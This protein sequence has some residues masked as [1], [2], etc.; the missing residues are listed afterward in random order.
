[1]PRYKLRIANY[2]LRIPLRR[3][4]PLASALGIGIAL[5]WLLTG[6]TRPAQASPAE[7]LPQ[8]PEAVIRYVDA[9]VGSDGSDC[10]QPFVLDSRKPCATIQWA[11]DVAA[12]GDVVKV[13]LG[14]YNT[15]NGKGGLSQVVYIDKQVTVEGGY[16]SGFFG[17]PN[18]AIPAVID[19]GNGGR[20][21]V[22]TGSAPATLRGFRVTH[23][24]ASALNGNGGG[25]LVTGST[26]ATLEFV[27]VEDSQA[28]RGGGLAVESGSLTGS[29]VVLQRN[30]A[31]QNG[32][33]AF[34]A[35]G[36]ANITNGAIDANTAV[37][38]GGVYAEGGLFSFTGAAMRTNIA[39]DRGGAVFVAGG[40]AVVGGGEVTAN[41]APNGGGAGYATGGSLHFATGTIMHENLIVTGEGQALY[42]TNARGILTGTIIQN[43]TGAAHA[44]YAQESFLRIT[45]GSSLLNNSLATGDGGALAAHGGW[46]E[47]ETSSALGNSAPAGNGGAFS[48]ITSTLVITGGTLNSNTSFGHG[49]AIYALTTTITATGST[50]NENSAQLNGGA[51]YILTGTVASTSNSLGRNSA[52]QN[53]GAIFGNDSGLVIDGGNLTDNRVTIGSGGGIFWN[54]QYLTGTNGLVLRGNLAGSDAFA[55]QVANPRAIDITAPLTQ[56]DVLTSSGGGI[57]AR[58]VSMHLDEVSFD[59]NRAGYLG[60]ALYVT[61]TIDLITITNGL[62]TSNQAAFGQG[63]GFYFANITSTVTNTLFS[64]NLAAWGGGLYMLGGHNAITGSSFTSNTA[65]FDGGGIYARGG[66]VSFSQITAQQ[67]VA[68]KGGGLFALG[69]TGLITSSTIIANDAFHDGGGLYLSGGTFS[70]INNVLARNRIGL[71]TAKGSALYILGARVTIAH[72]TISNNEHRHLDGFGV[73]SAIYAAQSST[74]LALMNSIIANHEEGLAG[75]RRVKVEGGGNVW[76]NNSKRNWSPNLIGVDA[77]NYFG[78]PLFL[79]PASLDYN[80]QRKSAAWGVGLPVTP[81]LASDVSTD[82][83][84]GRRIAV[85]DAGAYEHRYNRGLNLEQSASPRVLTPTVSLRY[86]ITVSNYSRS[87][88]PPVRFSNVL[89][90]QQTAL[91]ITTDRGVCDPVALTCEL[92]AFNIGDVALISL[93][94]QVTG[95][96]LTGGIVTMTNQANVTFTPIDPNDSDTTSLYDTYLYDLL[97]DNT[98][99]E[100]YTAQCVVDLHGKLYP[101]IQ[102][103]V[104]ASNSITDVVKVSGYCG[105]TVTLDKELKI[106]G[107]WSTTMKLWD[108]EL[109][110][111]TLDATATGVVVTI[112]GQG[113]APVIESM[114]LRG[115]SGRKGGGIYISE[116]SAIISDVNIFLNDAVSGGGIFLDFFSTPKILHSEIQENTAEVAGG[117]VYLV[118]SGAKFDDVLVQNNTGAVDGGGMYLLKSAAEIANSVISNHVITGYGGGL[119]LDESGAQVRTS[120]LIS[121]SAGVGGAIYAIESPAAII[122]NRIFSN[123]ATSTP[124]FSGTV[125]LAPGGGGG[126]YA[127]RSDAKVGSSV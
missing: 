99:V 73:N 106:Q 60:G 95:E 1:M 59:G 80:I 88:L 43:H 34:A 124:E 104:D 126:I 27:T 120:L 97:L 65:N 29:N 14:T 12:A 40:T 11:I 79:N 55:R 8:A 102:A 54:G 127:E 86:A 90:P 63:G 83:A 26:Q 89:P 22:F 19:A 6:L 103:A 16:S 13:A 36:V 67:N 62:V 110:T 25:I 115:G 111:A 113:I 7:S 61:S 77:V 46:V 41:S 82:I 85:P 101:E 68:D 74:R 48:L 45:G 56:S 33:G 35:G 91:G 20:G 81:T 69:T 10:T 75:D 44:L 98:G 107:G 32:G 72:A 78:D 53:G 123:T 28:V 49:G 9:S 18:F 39:S 114:H 23:G 37:L 21:I 71:S 64:G 121:N 92:G 4:L 2:E 125:P 58:G 38:G 109:Y 47:L 17:S 112:L 15:R 50:L 57:F 116:A 70:L 24:N 66:R 118:E 93:D 122:L 94:A 51:L 100:T 84:L 42:L 119:Y 30:A 96:P 5:V 105:G 87:S 3:Y 117:G 108:P 76:W 31:S 52:K